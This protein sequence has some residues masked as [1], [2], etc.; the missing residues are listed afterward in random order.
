MEYID[1]YSE[2]SSTVSHD[3]WI[4]NRSRSLPR[5]LDQSGRRYSGKENRTLDR[6]S[7]ADSSICQEIR[8]RRCF[9]DRVKRRAEH[10]PDISRSREGLARS[11]TLLR[12]SKMRS[13]LRKSSDNSQADTQASCHSLHS[14]KSVTIHPEVTHYR[15]KHNI[16]R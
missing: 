13:N 5:N 8:E 7:M 10:V 15:Y 6:A 12:K 14:A 3:Y 4:S 9:T 11:E 2:E 16:P 1:D